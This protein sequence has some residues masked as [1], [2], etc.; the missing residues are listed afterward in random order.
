MKYFF[1]LLV[2]SFIIC[3]L[4]PPG[5]SSEQLRVWKEDGGL[6]RRFEEKS[7]RQGDKKW[8]QY[9]RIGVLF[10]FWDNDDGGTSTVSLS[11]FHV[12]NNPL[13]DKSV[14]YILT[15]TGFFSI[16]REGKEVT[17]RGKWIT[18]KMPIPQMMAPMMNGR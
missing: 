16:G 14:Q 12:P 11:N 18:N 1:A 7:T 17:G 9:D 15:P 6:G 4:L 10:G 5:V 8:A 3:Q 2:I 13:I